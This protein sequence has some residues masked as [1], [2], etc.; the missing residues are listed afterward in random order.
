MAIT[1]SK[2]QS[3]SIDV[4]LAVVIFMGA[5]F[6]FFI[7]I[8]Q[9]SNTKASDLQ[10]DASIVIKQVATEHNSL[11]VVD[12]NEINITKMNELKNLSYDQ[13]KEMLAIQGDF[14]IYIEDEQ[15]HIVLIN[16]SYKG[17]G[18]QKINISGTPCSQK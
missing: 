17:I 1:G 4:I 15:G 8:N 9:N 14:C 10:E 13:L 5:F 3:W 7:F 6:V 18:T 2:A 11:N 16:N 12:N